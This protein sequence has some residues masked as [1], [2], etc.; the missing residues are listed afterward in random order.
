MYNTVFYKKQAKKIDQFMNEAKQEN[1]HKQSRNA[2]FIPKYTINY[3]EIKS[4]MDNNSKD[5]RKENVNVN[6]NIR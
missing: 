5:N 6:E 1:Q 3:E 4:R 2:E